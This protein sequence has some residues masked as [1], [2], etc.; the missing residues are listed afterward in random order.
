MNGEGKLRTELT[1]RN[2]LF[3]NGP[4]WTGRSRF[5]QSLENACA[6]PTS[7]PPRAR[8]RS[9][10][11]KGIIVVRKTKKYLTPIIQGPLHELP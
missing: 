4:V 2:S 8:L 9:L 10:K 5:P 3:M 11:E 1:N 7:P 6:F